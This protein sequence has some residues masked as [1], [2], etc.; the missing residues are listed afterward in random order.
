M[1]QRHVT[2]SVAPSL[3]FDL[4]RTT[5]AN[6]HRLIHPTLLACHPSLVLNG[7]GQHVHMSAAVRSHLYTPRAPVLWAPAICRP[8]WNLLGCQ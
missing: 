3:S 4:C 7:P 1:R 2:G 8:V 6:F 5:I